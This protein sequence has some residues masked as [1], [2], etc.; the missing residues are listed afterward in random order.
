MVTAVIIDVRE[1][2]EFRE[3]GIPG[4][5]NL[6][7]SEFHEDQY[8]S[9]REN[10]ICLICQS[11]NRASRTKDQLEKIGFTNV[12]L[13]DRHMESIENN[14]SATGWSVDR[15]FRFVLGILIAISMIGFFRGGIWF[16]SLSIF[17]SLGLTITASIDRCYLRVL[18]AKMPWN[19]YRAS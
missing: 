3:N 16:L 2:R 7:L 10:L 8:N 6:P 5:V 11:G 14:E 12:V 9:Y 1:P 13:L 18:I 17:V 15:Q 19:H 4:A